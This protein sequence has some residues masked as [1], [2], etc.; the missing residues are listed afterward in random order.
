M[1]TEFSTNRTAMADGRAFQRTQRNIFLFV[2]SANVARD[3]LL[4]CHSCLEE[5]SSTSTFKGVCHILTTVQP[6]LLLLENV[7]SID[8]PSGEDE[9][10]ESPA[11]LSTLPHSRKPLVTCYMMLAAHV[12][13]MGADVDHVSCPLNG[14]SHPRLMCAGRRSNLDLVLDHIHELGLGYHCRAEKM[15]ASNFGLPQ[16]RSRYYIMGFRD[17]FA[18]RPSVMT[19][20][21]TGRINALRCPLQSLEA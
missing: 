21:L 12:S 9:V 5:C 2:A 6:D 7:D 20:Q 15:K 18:D 17:V 16:R 19:S 4:L 10:R 8:S 13:G 1:N 14:T 3:A 11:L